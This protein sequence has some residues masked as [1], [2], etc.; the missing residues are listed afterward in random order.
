[1]SD[2]TKPPAG[3]EPAKPQKEVDWQPLIDAVA[4]RM[5]ELIERF[6]GTIAQGAKYNLWQDVG[7]LFVALAVLFIVGMVAFYAMVAGHFDVA[8]RIAIPLISFVGGFGLGRLRAP[9][10]RA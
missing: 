7:V 3:S 1:M 5:G 9:S 2:E 10:T 4:P 8:E 6:F